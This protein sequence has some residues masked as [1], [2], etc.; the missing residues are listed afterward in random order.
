M[1]TDLN[2]LHIFCKV[3]ELESFTAAARHL[4]QPK[5]RISRAIARL[6]ETMGTQLVR[7][8]TRQ[9]SLTEEGKILYQRTGQLLAQINGEL[10]NLSEGVGSISG[11]IRVSASEDL[12]QAILAPIISNFT[13]LYPHIRFDVILTNAYVDLSAQEVDVAFR[14]GKLSD[15]ALIQKKIGQVRLIPVAHPDYLARFGTPESLS[16]L[17]QHRLLNFRSENQQ[18][19]STIVLSESGEG[20]NFSLQ[21]NSFTILLQ[22]ALQSKGI[23]LLPDFYC[24]QALRE[25]KLLHILPQW[26][27]SKRDIQLVYLPNKNLSPRVKTFISYVAQSVGGFL[28]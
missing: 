13:E 24:R 12:G 28:A 19:Q 22:L 11:L 27:G 4:S 3:A 16:A 25:G 21:A 20:L 23:T 10:T 18:G 5:S 17:S 1:K 26:N 8:T 2:L 15:S 14:I 7:R 6:E 9:T